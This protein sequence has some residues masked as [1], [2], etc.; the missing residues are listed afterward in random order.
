[1]LLNRAKTS[2][3]NRLADQLRQTSAPNADLVKSLVANAC[4]RRHVRRARA[5]A[6]LANIAAAVLAFFVFLC[7]SL[8]VPP[9]WA[10][11]AES[12]QPKPLSCGTIKSALGRMACE[13]TLG[14]APLHPAKEATAPLSP[15]PSRPTGR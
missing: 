8:L 10:A 5:E 1:M 3:R 12:T 9:L 2:L 15:Q 4:N 7:A 14:D 13:D 6:L 11:L